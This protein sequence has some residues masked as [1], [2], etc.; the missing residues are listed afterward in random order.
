MKTTHRITRSSQD[1]I[2]IL[3]SKGSSW[4]Y[5]AVPPLSPGWCVTPCWRYLVPSCKKRPQHLAC[6]SQV[7]SLCLMLANEN[8]VCNRLMHGL[9]TTTSYPKLIVITNVLHET[10]THLLRSQSAIG[11][12]SMSPIALAPCRSAVR[13][14]ADSHPCARCA[15]WEASIRVSLQKS[16]HQT[17]T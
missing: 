10:S 3:C 1:V 6:T 16:A 17:H 5:Q 4:V 15:R 14:P 8:K 12:S 11:G 13:A 7:R 9:H 2:S